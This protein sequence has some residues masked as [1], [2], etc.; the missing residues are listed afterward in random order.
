MSTLIDWPIVRLLELAANKKNATVGGPF[1]SNLVSSDYVTAGVPVVRGVNLPKNSRFCCKKLVFVS[2]SKADSLKSNLAIPGDLVFTQ[3]G[4]LGQVGIIPSD[5][6]YT[7]F[8]ISQSQMK[9]SVDPDKADAEYLYYYFSLNSTINYIEN[10]ALQSGVPHINLGILRKIEI[11][12]PPIIIQK[13][14]AAVL[15][16]YD[17]LI[18]NNKHRIDILE[19]MAKEI[20]H[21]WFVRFRFPGYQKSQFEKGIPIGWEEKRIDSLGKVTTGKTP[22][23]SNET[24]YGGEIHFVKTP[25]MHGN[26][27]IN[28]T[29]ERLTEDGLNSQPSQIIP[30][31]SISVSCIGTGGV[32]S[33]TTQK[34]STNQQINSVT[35]TKREDLEW[36]Y[37]T[38]KALKQTIL[39]FGATGATMTNLS[40][41]K[42]A[43]IK[44]IVPPEDLRVAFHEMV[45]P[46]FNEIKSLMR[47][48]DNLAETK[49]ALLPRLI[50]GKLSVE[51]LDIK[52]PPS[53]LNNEESI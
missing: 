26:M 24:F 29:E 53:M 9:L 3:R 31:N 38:F 47:A 37:F 41:G 27:F 8:V 25:D 42:F 33:I 10:H 46:M 11:I 28:N 50:S 22:A 18:E 1:G 23:T 12:T 19:N 16:G 51:D 40:K 49:N 4:T 21:E 44:P 43:G 14:I 6:K 20:Y 34:S 35:L 30:K 36:A 17:D 52:F 32:V 39:A 45:S 13:K 2:E 5:T 15:K 48:N 7:R